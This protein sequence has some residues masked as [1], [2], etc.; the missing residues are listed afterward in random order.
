MKR[1]YLK[2][3]RGTGKIKNYMKYQRGDGLRTLLSPT[4]TLGSRRIRPV[5]AF[6]RRRRKSQ[7]GRGFWDKV[8]SGVKTVVSHPIVR[9]V[10]KDVIIPLAIGAIHKKMGRKIP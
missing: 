3:Q 2:Y 5:S 6:C 7:R 9:K 1:R 10:T 4:G 8:K